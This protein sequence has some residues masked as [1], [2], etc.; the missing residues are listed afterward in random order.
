MMQKTC[1]TSETSHDRLPAN[2]TNQKDMINTKTYEVLTILTWNIRGLYD[3]IFDP[4]LQEFFFKYD[5][6]LV[7]E[8]HTDA[9][10]ED[11]YAN[12]PNYDYV[13]FPRKKFT[14]TGTWS[15]WG[16]RHVHKD[17]ITPS[18]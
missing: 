6:I 16:N 13:N 9:T 1:P 2:I 17:T 4:D 18:L 3:K 8:T 14:P 7:T 5:I 12:I 15:I 10:S 11:Y